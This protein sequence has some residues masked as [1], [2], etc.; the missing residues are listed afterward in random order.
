MTL[1]RR[2]KF[3]FLCLRTRGVK[4]FIGTD[5]INTIKENRHSVYSRGVNA[6]GLNPFQVCPLGSRAVPKNCNE[7][8]PP[9]GHDIPRKIAKKIALV[10]LNCKSQSSALQA[11]HK[12]LREEM[13]YKDIKQAVDTFL[14][15]HRRLEQYFF[16]EPWSQLHY[17]DS[18]I[19]FNVMKTFQGE[20]I[21][22][23]AVH[24]SFVVPEQEEDRLSVVMTS[25]YLE[26]AQF[27][28]VISKA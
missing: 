9:R 8:R 2:S 18:S 6:V 4:L 23:I 16:R 25:R 27:E 1:H 12:E 3:L 13:S 10:C 24:D 17:W 19:A 11:L 28:P 15:A 7:T 26:L 22:I 5:D 14:K 21:P 20:N